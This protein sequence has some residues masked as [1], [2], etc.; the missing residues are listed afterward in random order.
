VNRTNILHSGFLHV[1][2]VIDS[3]GIKSELRTKGAFQDWILK[4]ENGFCISFLGR[5]V[6]DHSDD[7]ASE[8]PK[9]PCPEWILW[10]P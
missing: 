4:S 2:S 10:F 7:G 1:F 6:Q 8:E 3:M 5:L 9:N